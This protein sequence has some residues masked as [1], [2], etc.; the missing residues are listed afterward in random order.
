MRFKDGL[1]W[2][3]VVF[4]FVASGAIEWNRTLLKYV[5]LSSPLT[6][7]PGFISRAFLV[8]YS[9]VPANM[10]SVV[11]VIMHVLLS[12]CPSDCLAVICGLVA[13]F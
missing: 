11:T 2:F 13:P 1:C 3:F 4:I 10:A 6:T 8:S 7:R 9:F 12:L 5:W